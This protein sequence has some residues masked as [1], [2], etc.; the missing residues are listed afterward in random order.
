[1]RYDINHPTGK[2]ILQKQSIR[3][4]DSIID[5]YLDFLPENITQNT[6]QLCEREF[7]MINNVRYDIKKPQ[8]QEVIINGSANGCDSIINI[9][10]KFFN[11]SRSTYNTTLCEGTSIQIHGKTY[12]ETTLTGIDTLTSADQ[13]KCDSI[14]T[15]MITVNKP[16]TF[17]YRNI[18][19][20]Q[21]SININGNIFN[22]N[23]N[24]IDT[25]QKIK[26]DIADINKQ[27]NKVDTI[28]QQSPHNVKLGYDV[29]D[30]KVLTKNLRNLNDF[31]DTLD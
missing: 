29:V 28:L 7:I 18:I 10:L 27:L 20:E 13:N 3:Q 23:N 21:D 17:Q 26:T 11:S 31:I 22:K 24:N 2:E 4:C 30:I 15:I 8:G 14:V 6:T 12:N 25:I 9:D 19:C 16:H 5:I 1:M